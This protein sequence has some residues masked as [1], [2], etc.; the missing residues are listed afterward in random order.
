MESPLGIGLFTVSSGYFSFFALVVRHGYGQSR[1][2][3]KIARA[4][5][6]LAR[7]GVNPARA[8]SGPF[9]QHAQPTISGDDPIRG[10]IAR[11]VAAAV[12]IVVALTIA[13]AVALA[14]VCLF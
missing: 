8:G 6:R 11:P 14:V 1:R 10:S 5:L 12:T 13:L 7:D 2:G 3:T 9:G 4:I